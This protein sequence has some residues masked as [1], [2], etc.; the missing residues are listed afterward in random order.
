MV[1]FIRRILAAQRALAQWHD[2]MFSTRPIKTF[3]FN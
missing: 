2:L 3:D 1:A